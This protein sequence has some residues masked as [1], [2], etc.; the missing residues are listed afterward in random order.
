MGRRGEIK[1]LHT[2]PSLVLMDQFWSINIQPE[3]IDLITRFWGI[4]TEF[5]IYSP[6]WCWGL[7]LGWILIH[8]NWSLKIFLS[9]NKI[10]AT[11]PSTFSFIVV[12]ILI[13]KFIS[14]KFLYSYRI[15]CSLYNTLLRDSLSWL[16]FHWSEF[17][18]TPFLTKLGPKLIHLF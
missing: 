5:G 14:A 1:E 4:T 2:W 6:E 17:S 16:K 15:L 10:S 13:W 7:V 11:F 12:M 8:R 9:G 3:S 18:C